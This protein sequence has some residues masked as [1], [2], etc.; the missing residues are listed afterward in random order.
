[1]RYL[2]AIFYSKVGFIG[3]F[4]CVPHRQSGRGKTLKGMIEIHKEIM[5]ETLAQKKSLV[6]E[7][8]F[9]TRNLRCQSHKNY[10][11]KDLWKANHTLISQH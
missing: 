3:R 5:Q 4:L 10:A 1:M 6:I 7:K 2:H 11:Y 9:P 8:E